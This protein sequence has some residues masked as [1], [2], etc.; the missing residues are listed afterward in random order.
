MNK[1]QRKAEKRHGGGCW[2]GMKRKSRRTGSVKVEEGRGQQTRRQ[3][4]KATKDRQKRARG[5]REEREQYKR[6]GEIE[7]GR[8]TT[9]NHTQ[10]KREGL[11]RMKREKQQDGTCARYRPSLLAPCC[12]KGRSLLPSVSKQCP[13]DGVRRMLQGSVSRHRLL[14]TGYHPHKKD[15]K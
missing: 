12:V 11:G 5:G 6:G 15:Y 10:N 13:A 8:G 3:F 14:D 9:N 4:L 1:W 2:I 7:E